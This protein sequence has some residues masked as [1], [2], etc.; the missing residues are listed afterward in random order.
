MYT[1]QS[2]IDRIEIDE[3][4]R[5]RVRETTTVFKDGVGKSK[6][7]WRSGLITPDQDLDK[8]EIAPNIS[9]QDKNK[10]KAVANAVWT[11]EVVKAYK[12]AIILNKL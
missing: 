8:I 9:E 12:E 5:F 11:P 4:G 7:Y 2:V 10:V 6:S 3:Y 1:E